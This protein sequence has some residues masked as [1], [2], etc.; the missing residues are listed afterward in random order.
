MP[1][2]VEIATP[3]RGTPAQ[4]LFAWLAMGGPIGLIP[5]VPATWASLLTALTCRALAPVMRSPESLGLW[6]LVFLFGGW[7]CGAAEYCLDHHDPRNVVLDEI[8]GQWLVFLLAPSASWLAML[9]GFGLFRLLDVVKPMPARQLERLPAGWGI[10]AD[11]AMAGI[12][13]G[14]ALWLLLRWL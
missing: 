7:A 2:H 3:R 6:V 4:R 9:A 8:S 1:V 5:W 10:M 12:Y 11:D 13:A 14:I